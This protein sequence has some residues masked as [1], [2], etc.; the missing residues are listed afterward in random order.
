MQTR[1]GE[2]WLATP[3]RATLVGYY[4]HPKTPAV[5]QPAFYVRMLV[6]SVSTARKSTKGRS[7]REIYYF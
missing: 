2:L 7:E 4:P 6:T 5:K 1:N 3:A